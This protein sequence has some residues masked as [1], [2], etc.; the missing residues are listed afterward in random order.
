MAVLIPGRGLLYTICKIILIF[1]SLFP[2]QNGGPALFRSKVA[3]YYL[4]LI[5]VFAFTCGSALG[6]SLQ[7]EIPAKADVMARQTAAPSGRV[8]VKFTETSQITV[9][10]NGLAGPDKGTLDSFQ[11]LLNKNN[12]GLK[13]DRRFEQSYEFLAQQRLAG[14]TKARRQLPDLNAY[15]VLD[16]SHQN[17][18][19]SE[20]LDVLK[21]IL[22]E[23]EPR[24][25]CRDTS[26][27]KHR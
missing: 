22:A 14:M 19:R 16:F 24:S 8:V 5:L 23:N 1:A 15:G 17:L 18:S 11:N 9:R 20:L 4:L 12:S 2:L 6:Q 13:V 10:E 3:R 7:R 27:K 26:H 21:S 25:D